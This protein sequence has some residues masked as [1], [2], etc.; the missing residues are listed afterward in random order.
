MMKKDGD[1]EHI[2]LFVAIG[3]MVI[4]ALILWKSPPL[5]LSDIT[6][7]ITRWLYAGE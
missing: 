4:L 1:S 6:A 5:S 7:T 3:V 2:I